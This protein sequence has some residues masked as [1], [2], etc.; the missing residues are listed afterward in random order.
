MRAERLWWDAMHSKLPNG[1]DVVAMFWTHLY[2]TSDDDV[3]H[4]ALSTSGGKEWTK[5][6]PTNL[7]GQVC[8]PIPL[9]DGS[10]AAIYNFRKGPPEEHGVH[11]ALCANDPSYQHFA[12]ESEL[13]LFDAGKE[14]TLGDPDHENFLA[15]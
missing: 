12:V 1:R 4:V 13:V 3:N 15:E 5:P 7:Q 8:A 2:G 11:V 14:A 6:A 9:A 10:L